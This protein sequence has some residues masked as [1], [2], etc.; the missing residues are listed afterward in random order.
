MYDC[1]GDV[2]A[3][4]DAEVTLKQ[5]ERTAMRD[6]RNS[7][8]DRLKTRL[9]ASGKPLPREFIK[10]GSYAMKTMV[11]DADNDYDIDDGVYFT[12]ESL[13]DANGI[14]M[15]PEAARQMVCAALQDERFSRPPEVKTSCVRVFYE[16]GYHVDLPVYRVVQ[17]PFGERYELAAGDEWRESRAADVEEWFADR[18]QTLSPDETNG[19]QFRRIVRMTKKFARSRK[20]WK[21]Q[22]A[23]GFTVTK[24]VEEHYRAN[25]ARE[26]SALRD[27]MQA[28]YGRLCWN[29]EV[30]HPVTPGTQLTSGPNDAGTTYLRD[31]LK[32]ALAKLEVLDDPDCTAKQA[33]AAWDAVFN[34]KF[35][36]DR[37]AE[38]VR[39]TESNSAILANLVSTRDQPRQYHK[40]GGGRFA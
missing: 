7:N 26:D 38:T 39:K 21:S 28:I 13:Q 5:P 35:F 27:T 33:A 12:R 22:V 31:R 32:E 8:R 17:T 4:H 25:A 2:L 36:S 9:T 19:R 37:L 20:S 40:E 3:Y 34:T 6:R 16:E 24:L 23:P 15:K 30:R 18:N 14:D 1:S 10:Q 11:K 29:L